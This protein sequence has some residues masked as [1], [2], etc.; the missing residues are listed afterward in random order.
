MDLTPDEHI[1]VQAAIQRWVDSSISKTCNVPNYYTVDQTRQ[2]YELMYDLGAKGGTI[3]RDGSRDEQVLELN[4]ED[5]ETVNNK[6]IKWRARPNTLH[7]YTYRKA[8][9]I[10]TAYITVNANGDGD[11]APFEVFVNVGKAGS[12]V[13]ADAEGLGRLIS[14]LLRVP[15]PL[16]PEERIQNI[17]AQLQNIGSGNPQGFGKHRVMSLPDAVSQVLAEH[18]GLNTQQVL[19]GMPEMSDQEQH[20]IQLPLPLKGDYCPQCGQASMFHVEGCRKCFSCGYSA[21]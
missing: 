11:A 6:E 10:G 7:G 14:L 4:E 1:R 13:S 17:V 21:C 18:V 12:D 2:L 19:P 15:S 5:K 8:T 9:P 20:S 3:Y 16:S